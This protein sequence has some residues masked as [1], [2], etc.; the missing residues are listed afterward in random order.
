MATVGPLLQIA[1]VWSGRG[2]LCAPLMIIQLKNQ[3]CGHPRFLKQLQICQ[4]S[5]VANVGD[6]T[7]WQHPH[8]DRKH[9]LPPIWI[10]TG[11]KQTQPGFY[12][13]VPSGAVVRDGH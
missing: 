10:P 6:I 11:G 9:M 3:V 8:C 13:R 1:G 12:A 7:Q 2:A 4:P 5:S